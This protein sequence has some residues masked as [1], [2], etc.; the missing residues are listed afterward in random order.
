[1]LQGPKSQKSCRSELT[2][3]A[4]RRR[5][6]EMVM[7]QHR[8]ENMPMMPPCLKNGLAST[9]GIPQGFAGTSGRTCSHGKVLNLE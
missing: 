8:N 3:G 2:I 4:A 7:G 6:G 9:Q 5:R 1:M